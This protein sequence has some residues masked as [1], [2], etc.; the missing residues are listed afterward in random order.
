M[1]ET[2]HPW[3]ISVG[4]DEKI[5]SGSVTTHSFLDS[6]AQILVTRVI[7]CVTRRLFLSVQKLLFTGHNKKYPF[8]YEILTSLGSN[9]QMG[10]FVEVGMVVVVKL[11]RY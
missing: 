8:L 7:L 4:F 2:Y 9:L 6:R 10:H 11:V 3:Y 1:H 5:V